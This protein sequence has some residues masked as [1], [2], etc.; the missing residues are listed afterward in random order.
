MENRN[1]LGTATAL[2]IA[3]APGRAAALGP[4]RAR[5]RAALADW[6]LAALTDT[7]ELL[8][9][10]LAGNALRHT[11]AGAVFTARPTGS[12]RLRVEVAD[13]SAEVPRPRTGA[14]ADALT[15]TAELE[16]GGRGLLL[17]EALAADWGVRLVGRGKVTW[18]ELRQ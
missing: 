8:A 2:R 13:A 9:T 3:L 1:D 4:L 6:G 12:G 7:A 17:V 11:G 18:F 14:D 16:T 15:D 5:L 10:E